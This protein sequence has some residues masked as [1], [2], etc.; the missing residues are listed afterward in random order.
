MASA[1]FWECQILPILFVLFNI[2]F[3][4]Q[5][6]LRKVEEVL[7]VFKIHFLLLSGQFS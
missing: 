5:T 4:F 3:N 2:D 6:F 7:F 1:R